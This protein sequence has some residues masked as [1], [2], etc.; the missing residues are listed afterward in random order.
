MNGNSI[1]RGI[2]IGDAAERVF[3]VAQQLIVITKVN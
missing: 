2:I 3:Y 1:W